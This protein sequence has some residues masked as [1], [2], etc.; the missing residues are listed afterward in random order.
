MKMRC[1]VFAALV[2]AMLNQYAVADS[3]QVDL[4]AF[5]QADAATNA[6]EESWKSPQDLKLDL[7][8]NAIPLKFNASLEQGFS[9]ATTPQTDDLSN[10]LKRGNYKIIAAYSWLQPLQ[11]SSGKQIVYLQG[12]QRYGNHYEL[13]GTLDLS[14]AEALVIMPHVWL[15]SF[16]KR[17]TAVNDPLPEN[18]IIAAEQVSS[19]AP[20]GAAEPVKAAAP[21]LYYEAVQVME[22]S[23]RRESKLGELNY[24][25]HPL[26]GLLIRVSAPQ[27]STP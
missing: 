9:A 16:A 6:K 19:E 23:E 21:N 13:E 7:P 26:F 22:L 1:F 4:V 2:S 11:S 18:P 17:N 14:Q 8:K 5:S 3:V 27:T 10:N 12:G 24:F 20:A 15:S 25:D